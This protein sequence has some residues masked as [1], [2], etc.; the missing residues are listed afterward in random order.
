MTRT[1]HLADSLAM[2]G[3]LSALLLLP[4]IAGCNP[5]EFDDLQHDAPV[6]VYSATGIFDRL[7][8]GTELVAYSGT[9]ASGAPASR[10]GTSAGIDSPYIVYDAWTNTE[11]GLRR[12]F[13]DGCDEPGE[14]DASAGASLTGVPRWNGKRMCLIVGAPSGGDLQIRC[15]DELINRI[16]LP[17]PSGERFGAE[18]VGLPEGSTVGVA[19]IGAPGASKVYRLPEDGG[20]PIEVSMPDGVVPAG[21]DYGLVL[22][23]AALADGTVPGLTDA[24]LLV[25]TAPVA[26]RV[27]IAAVNA[28][29]VE[30]LGCVDGAEG[31]GGATAA[32]DLDGDGVPE[33]V[34]GATDESAAISGSVVVYDVSM[35]SGAVGCEAAG[36]TDDPTGVTIAC[37]EGAH[38]VTC[39]PNMSFGA[40]LAIGDVDA[41]RVGDLIVGAPRTDVDGQ[42][43]AGAVYLFR[44]LPSGLDVTGVDVLIDSDPGAGDLLGAAVTMT[45]THLDDPGQV[46]SEPVAGAPGSEELFVFL[47]S[48]LAN[49]TPLIGPR[50]LLR[51]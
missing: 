23:A 50:C 35:L 19:F 24:V 4:V 18:G 39:D 51:N 15:E 42:H 5:T 12:I 36:T 21:G 8:Y 1:T 6:K 48:A 13:F 25:A 7:G 43:A 14:C 41:D 31:H 45:Q 28:T 30:V 47:C 11:P 22:S 40:S 9:L 34:I 49:D 38:G 33:V 26:G 27:V 10:F 29:D 16:R 46:R 32:G 20:A 2:M 3:S 17:G 37:P 44:G